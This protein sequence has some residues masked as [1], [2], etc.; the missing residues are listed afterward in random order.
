MANRKIDEQTNFQIDR[1]INKQMLTQM[2]R[3]TGIFVDRLIDIPT[4]P[5]ADQ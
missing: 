2:D 1:H 4:Y 5:I 3:Y